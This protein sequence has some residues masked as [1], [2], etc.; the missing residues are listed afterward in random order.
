MPDRRQA[1]RAHLSPYFHFLIM[2]SLTSYKRLTGTAVLGMAAALTASAQV[3]VVDWIGVDSNYL[4]PANWSN[5]AVPNGTSGLRLTATPTNRVM[6]LNHTAAGAVTYQVN[7]IRTGVSLG[8]TFNLSGNQNGWLTYNIVGRGTH[9]FNTEPLTNSTGNAANRLSFYMNVGPYTTISLA[10]A[11]LLASGG[12]SGLIYAEINLMGNSN[13][14]A[15]GILGTRIELGGINMEQ[16]TSLNVGTKALTIAGATQA[17]QTAL[18]AGTITQTNAAAGDTQKWGPGITRVTSTGVVNMPTLW[19]MRAGTYLVDG[20]HNGPI[21]INGA[22]TVGGT[23][24]I[25]G[26]VTTNL[27]GALAPGGRQAAGTLTINGN[28]TL[29]GSLSIDLISPTEFDRLVLNGILTLGPTGNLAVGLAD[30]F[31][32]QPG[33]FRVLTTNQP[34]VGTF[35][36]VALPSS[37]GLAA[38]YVLGSNYLDINFTQ[39]AFGTNPLLVGNHQSIAARIDQAVLAGTAPNSLLD[40]LNRQPS[41]ILFRQVLD[42][43]SPTTYQSWFPSAVVRTNSMVQTVDDQLFQDARMGR[44]DGSMQSFFQGY[45]QESSRDPDANA[46]YSN[47]DTMAALGGFDYAFG[48]KLVV[49]GF[50]NYET[51]DFDLDVS[52][53]L[54]TA[55]SI[56][57]GAYAR[58]TRGKLQVTGT[59]FAGTDEYESKRS[60]VRTRLGTWALAETKGSRYGSSVTAAYEIKTPLFDITPTVGAQYLSWDAKAFRETG[61]NGANL[62]VKYQSEAS[63]ASRV[64]FRIAR[65][66]EIKAGTLRPFFN[67]AWQHEFKDGERNLTSELFG[68]TYTIKATGI[69]ANGFRVDT[70]VDWNIT[71]AISLTARYITEQGGAADESVGVRGGLTIAF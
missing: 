3:T 25:N 48:E 1:D 32:L 34:I 19:N 24:V 2:I 4:N 30:S 18:W 14:D 33:T 57:G 59:A 21:A 55:E 45:R 40:T 61:S 53:G 10:G 44:R 71:Q 56:T 28:V 36:S 42:E 65:S 46:A 52:G 11:S 54:S 8:Y 35:S 27:N 29:N 12:T 39:L 37:Q 66:F 6:N 58:H 63:L 15:S 62:R 47:Y 43:L 7:A 26:N 41:V 31:P 13:I 60:I 49:G 22:T 20:I 67:V 9:P 64:G 17:G 51:T 68:G 69:D 70:G 23:G 50:L 16:G 38:S 5:N